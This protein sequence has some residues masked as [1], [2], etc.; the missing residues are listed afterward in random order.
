MKAIIQYHFLSRHLIHIIFSLW[1]IMKNIIYVP[2]LP[3][4]TEVLKIQITQSVTQA[5]RAIA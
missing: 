1:C 5:S 3:N 2:S 4:N